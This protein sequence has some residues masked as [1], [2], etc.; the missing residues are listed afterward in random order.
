VR[1]G[2]TND[3]HDRRRTRREPAEH[4]WVP[5][6]FCVLCVCC[7]DVVVVSLSA[8]GAHAG[9]RHRRGE[10]GQAVL[11]AQ[12]GFSATGQ[13]ARRVE[14]G[15]DLTGRCWCNR[16]RR[17]A[18]GRFLAVGPSR[19][20][21]GGN[22]GMPKCDPPRRAGVRQW[23]RSALGN[24]SE[25]EPPSLQVLDIVVADAKAGE[26]NSAAPDAAV[27]HSA[28]RISRASAQVTSRGR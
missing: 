9:G 26:A 6:D 23:Q 20:G 18:A 1:P 14:R 16:T 25:R 10:R 7:R 21:G 5:R 24:L 3:P 13:R 8:A 17:P 15:R 28:T 11:V 27:R 22:K 2:R 12:C 4:I 19:G